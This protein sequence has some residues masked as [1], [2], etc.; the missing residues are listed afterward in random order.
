MLEKVRTSADAQARSWISAFDHSLR[1]GDAAAVIEMFRADSHWRDLCGLSW[2]MATF[3]GAEKLSDELC[4]HARK[5]GAHGF[6]VDSELMPPR[7][8][9]VAGVEVIEAIFRFE[10]ING[11]GMGVV[12]L[13]PSD[14]R[15]AV[16]KAWMISTLLDMEKI[17]QAR[18]ANDTRPSRNEPD[19]LV[20]GG[21]HAGI[22]A[23]VELKRI[24][25]DALVIDKE[26]RIGDN[27]RLRYHGLKL[28]NKTPVNHLR[29]L[30]FPPG[31]P[32]YIPKD[33][34]ANWLESYVERMEVNFWTRTTFEGAEYDEATG[35][36]MAKVRHGDGSVRTLGPK[37]IVMATSVS[38]TPNIPTI[39]TIENFAGPILHS[40][41]FSGGAE[42]KGKSVVVMGTGTSAHDICQGLQA[43]GA[44]V[45]MVQRS[46]T[47]VVNVEPAQLYDKT[48]LGEGPHVDVRD[49]LNASVPLAVTKASHR[50]ITREVRELDA[51]LLS[52]LEK[53]GFRL[54]FGEDDT[55]W[56]LKFRTRG[57]GYYFNVGC[58]ELIADGKIRL[59][60]AAEI[61]KFAENGL[62][63]NDGSTLKADLVVLATG[64]K[65]LG[66]IVSSLF[67]PKVAARVGP[68]WGFDDS[69]E[70]RNMW[71]RTR[72]PGLWFTAGSFSQCRIYSRFIALQIDA[73]EQGRLEKAVTASDRDS[74]QHHESGT[75]A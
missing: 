67:G 55:G 64:Y 31:S 26:A 63:L 53:V 21:G 48:Y 2:H 9:M 72:Q 52:R 71:T 6:E 24:G 73:I 8:A 32:D 39:A 65:G 60:Q 19:V 28:H 35:S 51:A 47:L 27:W 46:P 7:E 49:I 14:G 1:K 16:P 58:S 56:P 22:S 50:L 29:Y 44:G 41:Q 13:L 38:G 25:L 43:N 30:P 42:W 23:A 34:I 12:R 37:H 4:R 54:E 75:Y 33:E 61:M 20:V 70:L 3:S 66:H 74:V 17:G 45:T 69:Q 10:S 5:V 11:S 68:I 18:S 36:W 59:I 15:E 57:G 62:E 40:S